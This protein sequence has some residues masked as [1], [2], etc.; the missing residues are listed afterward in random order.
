MNINKLANEYKKNI[1]KINMRK[2]KVV[3]N[4][5][6]FAYY[7]KKYQSINNT[8]TNTLF[9]L[10]SLLLTERFLTGEDFDN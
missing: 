9:D 2:A 3:P 4:E 6:S 1:K 8:I 7:D 5:D 10:D